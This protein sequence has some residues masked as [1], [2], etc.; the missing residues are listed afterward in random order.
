MTKKNEVKKI[1]KTLYFS[2]EAIQILKDLEY[3]SGKSQ[4]ALADEGV[5]LLIKVPV[6]KSL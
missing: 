3:T 6:T 4:S 5:K 1:K 2:P